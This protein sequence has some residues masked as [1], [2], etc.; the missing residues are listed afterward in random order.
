MTKSIIKEDK[1]YLTHH[2]TLQLITGGTKQELKE[3]VTSKSRERIFHP[4]L[5]VAY[6]KPVFCTLQ[7]SGLYSHILR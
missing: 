5:L 1:A 6:V 3:P 2:S 7:S 4:G